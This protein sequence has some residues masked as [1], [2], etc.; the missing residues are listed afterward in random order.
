[1]PRGILLERLTWTRD[2]AEE[3]QKRKGYDVNPWL[4]AIL[5]QFTAVPDDLV[6]KKIDFY[7]EMLNWLLRCRYA[8]CAYRLRG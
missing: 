5:N 8:K 3:F 1:M 2:F 6:R 7:E 4:H